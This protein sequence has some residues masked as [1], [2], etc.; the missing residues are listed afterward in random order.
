MRD[1]HEQSS[2][3][4]GIIQ[5]IIRNYYREWHRYNQM[6]HANDRIRANA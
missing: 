6:I 3:D 5:R 4:R 1:T 2:R